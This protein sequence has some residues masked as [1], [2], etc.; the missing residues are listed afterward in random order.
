MTDS[1][2]KILVAG[3]LTLALIASGCG[4]KPGV[5]DKL[6]AAGGVLPPGATV[7]EQGEIVDS[8]GNVIGTTDSSGDLSSLGGTTSGGSTTGGTST[9]SGGSTTGGTSTTSGGSSNTNTNTNN[10]GS[11]DPAGAPSGGDA[12]GVTADKITIGTHAP[13]T[14]AAPVPSDSA[15]K[16]KDIYFKWMADQGKTLFGR[17]VEVILRNDN[18]NPSQAVAVCKEMVEKDHVFLL[19]GSAGT[20]QIQACARYAAS[21]NV[22][23]LS[24]GVTEV[25]LTGLPGYFANSMTYADQA[26]LLTDF[27]I[28]DLGAKD[29]KNGML[30]FDTPNFQDAHDAFISS[31]D[32]AGAEVV[33][34]RAVSKGADQTVAQTVVQ[35]M[36]TQGIENVYV[37]TSPIFFIQVLQASKTQ[38]YTPQWTGVG[39]TMTFDTVATVGCRNGTLSGAK[40]FAPFPAWVDRNKFDPDFA[41]AMAKFYPEENGGDDFIWL[42]WSGTKGLWDMLELPGKELTRERFVWFLE[43]ARGLSNG[44]GPELNFAPDDHYGAA[45]VHVNEAQCSGY[46]A[47]DSRWHTIQSFVSDF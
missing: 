5:A 12:T 27:L 3:A 35:E 34:D 40:F 47:G 2:R 38:S 21:V 17:N 31:M 10:G 32:K 24:A 23:Y 9:T 43:R 22:P 7:N 42:G 19:S 46:K 39:I 33:Y 16:G 29:E 36:K 18:Y 45:E 4:Q 15:D 1:T 44:I 8:S 11:N 37:L 28:S 41:K 30:R 26:P 14:G 6:T 13:L 25:G 20:D